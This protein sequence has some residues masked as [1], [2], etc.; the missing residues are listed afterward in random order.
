MHRDSNEQQAG[1]SMHGDHIGSATALF[2]QAVSYHQNNEL[3]KAVECYRKTIEAAPESAEAYYNI[4]V[5]R[6]GQM[7]WE[8]SIKEFKKVLELKPDFA[9]AAFNLAAAYKEAG[10]YQHAAQAYQRVV[11]LKPNLP[12]AF[13][14]Q[15]ICHL[16][17]GQ[18][19]AAIGAFEQASR[20][21]ADNPLYWF[22]L[23]EANLLNQ[24]H[25]EAV[26][27]YRR[28]VDLKPDWDSAHHNLAVALRI[29]GKMDDAI[30]HLKL[31]VGVNPDF[32]AAHAFLYRLAQHTCDWPLAIWA[33]KQLD[34]LSPME[35]TR[36]MKCAESPMT[37]IRRSSDV[38]VNMQVAR[39]WSLS[40]AQQA[41]SISPK[42]SFR[43]PA[44]PDRRI[45]VGY[46]SNDF[47]DH[48]VAH[49]IRG[50]LEN[51]DRRKF[52]IFG[53]A[54]NSDD[55]T[56]YRH[57]LSRSC[58]HFREIH[59]LSDPAAAAMINGD[60]IQILVDMAG[61]SRDNRLGIAALRPAPVQVSYLGF[62]GTTGADFIDYI[63]ADEVVVP[64]T[65]EPFYSEKIA[66]LPHCY[67]ANDD[68]L[69][70][71]QRQYARSD[72][73]LPNEGVIFCCFNQPYKIDEPLFATWMRIL[74]EVDGSVLWLVK[75]SPTARSNLYRAAEL[76]GVD[77]KR[78]V[79]TG[80]MPLEHNLARLRLA[81]LVL[82][83]CIY[84]GGATTSNALWAGV[85][86]LTMLGSHWVSRMSASALS[87]VGLPQLITRD[88]DGYA[89]LAIHLGNHR[90]ALMELR[91]QLKALR[92]QAPLFDTA[93]F[94]RHLEQAYTTMFQ[95]HVRS[96]TPASFKV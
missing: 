25:S 81:D 10:Q 14:Y 3:E 88:L 44:H 56:R 75:R 45:R 12:D 65:H 86:V 29:Q 91:S 38:G 40:V 23:A 68:R 37:S 16:K 26:D 7:L 17:L 96:M 22:H 80:F 87:A 62:L 54:I 48:A 73:S 94:T 72:F 95:R 34:R 47:K 70:I 78:L 13:F 90:Q 18:V 31:A 35:Q 2:S 20:L 6:Y 92:I 51:H 33:N 42:P 24:S 21:D 19:Q 1:S 61:H 69:P 66:Y 79:F 53:Y 8:A 58:D 82:D 67:Q 43:S 5:I 11:Q 30:A 46:L 84:N 71:A 41:A 64:K 77:P 57:L 89:R 4:G 55:G 59:G 76:A 50:M 36:G 52:E 63:I 39:S 32:T 28:A 83:T 15:G 74:K 60:G 49:Q 85:P 27:C 93:L 9:D